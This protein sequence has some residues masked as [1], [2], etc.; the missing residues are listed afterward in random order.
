MLHKRDGSVLAR[1]LTA[2]MLVLAFSHSRRYGCGLSIALSADVTSI[3]P[4]FPQPNASNNVA[5]N[6]F[7]TLVGKERAGAHGAR[8]PN[9]GDR[10]TISVGIQ[11]EARR[12]VP[13]RLRIY[14]G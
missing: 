1:L 6:V 2:V 10:S 9:R 7:E 13:R 8:S 14:G 11:A 12:Q 5:S 3:D 4:P